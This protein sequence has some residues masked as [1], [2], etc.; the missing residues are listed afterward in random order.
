MWQLLS[1]LCHYNTRPKIKE[2]SAGKRAK[3]PNALEDGTLVKRIRK[4]KN[5]NQLSIS[6]S[7]GIF[8]KETPSFSSM[9]SSRSV[10]TP[11]ILRSSAW[12]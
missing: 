7:M 2:K 11:L 9:S 3:V 1:F 5:H 8:M 12:P 10:V 4:H 6:C